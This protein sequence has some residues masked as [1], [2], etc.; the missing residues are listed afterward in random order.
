MTDLISDYIRPIRV[1]VLKIISDTCLG[2][3][4]NQIRGIQCLGAKVNEIRS[5]ISG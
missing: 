3:E 4:D 2:V 1:L 5:D